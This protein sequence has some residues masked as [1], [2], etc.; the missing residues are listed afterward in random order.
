L[1]LSPAIVGLVIP[2]LFLGLY[3]LY[4]Y[5]AF[6]NPVAFWAARAS[7]TWGELAWWGVGQALTTTEANRYAP[8]VTVMRTYIPFALVPTL[9][10]VALAT[11]KQWIELA[12]FAL[13]LI[14]IVWAVGIWGLGRYSAACWPAFLPLGIWLAQR[15]RWQAPLIGMLAVFQG[16]FF[17]LFTHQFPIY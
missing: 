5:L 2:W 8:H 1:L 12:A 9:G 6:G 14:T 11:K 17:Y 16:L 10:A 7:P 13:V 15:P 3:C 4:Q